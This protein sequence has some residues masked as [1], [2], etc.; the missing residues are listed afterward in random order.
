MKELPH[1]AFSCLCDS[2]VKLKSKMP[3]ASHAGGVFKRFQKIGICAAGVLRINGIYLERMSAMLYVSSIYRRLA[4][5]ISRIS[6]I[7][8]RE[9]GRSSPSVSFPLYILSSLR[10]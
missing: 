1:F 2:P 5:Q 3:L 8:A 9:Y 4:S 10:A 7:S 6:E